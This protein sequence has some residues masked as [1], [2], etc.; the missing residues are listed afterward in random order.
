[1]RVL[2]A[3]D[4]FRGTLT[5]PEAARAI[6]TGWRR[7]RPDDVLVELPM[8]DG[9]EGTLETLV[10]AL[11][12][13]IAT[14]RVE[15]PLGDPVEAAFG[16]AETSVGRTGIVEMARASGL[17]LTSRREPLRASTFGTGEL[18]GSALEAGASRL[19]V[20]VGGSATTDGGAGMAQA[21]GARL[22]D[23]LGRP[24]P[25]GGVGLLELAHIDLSGMSR[26]ARSAQ[27]LA[28][29]DVDNPLTG[30][31]GAA[32]V[33]GPQKGAT[34]EDVVLLD[35]ALGHLAAVL[36]R[37]LAV[38]VREVRGGGAAGGLGAGLV[39]F[40]GARI[41]PGLEVVMEAIGFADRLGDCD[42]VLTGEGRLDET[43]LS[44]KV[45]GG[46]LAAARDVDRPAAV[47][48]GEA[49]IAPS[50]VE[51]AALVDRFGPERALGR[52]RPGLMRL[53]EE[54]ASRAE[55]LRS[56]T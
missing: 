49:A 7:V 35:R 40:L 14:A 18:I 31:R 26:G 3:P 42:L 16:L 54:L 37:D 30:P 29:S 39:A 15:G 17:A 21:L 5:A 27:V 12:G 19:V 20:C 2:V 43:S 48:C 1:M 28:A 22:E 38:D 52:A 25:R 32:R 24:I 4:K 46:V 13:E 47:L 6:A 44:G 53:A 56:P 50:G 34:P 10:E 23:G 36:H 8:A 45:V 11:G 41:R 51:T 33:F 9:G 55:T